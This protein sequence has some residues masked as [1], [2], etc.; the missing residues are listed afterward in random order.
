MKSVGHLACTGRSSPGTF[1][2]L[3]APVSADD[4]HS[5]VLLQPVGET[6]RGTILEQVQD[7]ASFQVHQDGA[8]A[9]SL[10]PG[11]IIDPQHPGRK[12]WGLWSGADVAQQGVWA[13]G[14]P[15]TGG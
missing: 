8:V 6:S 7:P 5:G 2:I 3:A 11:P 1:R 4:S 10:L 9:V 15:Q 14:K 13:D 12:K